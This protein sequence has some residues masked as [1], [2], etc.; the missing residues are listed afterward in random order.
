[1]ETNLRQQGKG[2]SSES[3]AQRE[4]TIIFEYSRIF[5]KYGREEA[6]ALLNQHIGYE[7]E[8]I[9]NPLVS[10]LE[11]QTWKLGVLKKIAKL[12]NSP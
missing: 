6:Y 9:R 12:I 10:G 5:A 4:Q 7:L 8:V 3:A 2:K 1:M 11:E